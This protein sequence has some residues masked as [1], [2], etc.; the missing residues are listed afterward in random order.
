MSTSCDQ[1]MKDGVCENSSRITNTTSAI[2]TV[3][4][5]IDIMN[6]SNNNDDK[7]IEADAADTSVIGQLQN[8]STTDDEDSSISICANCGKEGAKNICNK[9]KQVRYCNAVC[10]KVHKKKH[11][12]DCEE[13]L[14]LAAELHDIELFKQPP[15]KND[16]P[17]CFLRLPSLNYGHRYMSCCGKVICSG[18]VY[19]PVFDDQGNIVVGKKC[20]FCRTP[21]DSDEESLEKEKKRVEA[22]D[23]HAIYNLG[24]DYQ[25]GAHGMPRD[26]AKALEF[27]HRAAELGY[28]DAYLGIGNAYNVGRGVEVDKKK[29]VYY[30]KLAAIGGCVEARHNLGINE[31]EAG[32]SERALKHHMIAVRAGDNDSLKEIQELYSEGDATKGDYMKALQSYQEYLIE[33]KSRQ[34]DEA[35]AADENYRYY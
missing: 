35:A 4:N 29:A 9:C 1:K 2:D 30:T 12:N 14:R 23:A 10:K 21:L 26:Y 15:P 27:F 17:I 28:A 6:I 22:G 5:D 8:M 34:R 13:Y 16:C 24:C 32:N 18:C 20:P 19:A 31:E 3:S 11:K 33:I 25:Y 7:T